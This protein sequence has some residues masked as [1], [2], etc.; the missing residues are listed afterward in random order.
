VS[1][2][3]TR[4]AACVVAA[5]SFGV[6][7][8]C[9]SSSRILLPRDDTTTTSDATTSSSTSSTTIGAST[10]ARQAGT[11][12]LPP[13]AALPSDAECAARVRPA[14]ESRDD[15]A[16][17]N[18]VKGRQKHIPERWLDRVTG[19]FSGTTDEILQWAA[20]K[21]G[22]DPELFRSV[23]AVET[24]WKMSFVGDNGDS[25][26]LMQMRR[27]YHCCLP[28]MQSSTAFN[29][30]YYGG[31]LRS[32]YDGR[33]GWL[34]TVEHA[35]PYAAGDLWGSVGVWAS[36]RWHLYSSDGYVAKVQQDLAQR[37]WANAGF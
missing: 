4:T 35:M 8:S 2:H 21:W 34:N 36:G 11:P 22:F 16:G 5:I 1:W 26:G 27:P 14:P 15:N 25:F 20:Y 33:Q 13:G 3:R 28:F 6:L 30:D 29:V 10:P 32:Y 12:T 31:I 18:K 24:W 9:G 17:F 23:A 19:D 7:A 37:P